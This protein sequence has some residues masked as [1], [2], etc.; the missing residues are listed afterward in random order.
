M[1]RLDAAHTDDQVWLERGDSGLDGGYGSGD[2]NPVHPERLGVRCVA[3]DEHCAAGGLGNGRRGP[4]AGLERL[5]RPVTTRHQQSRNLGCGKQGFERRGEAA[6]FGIGRSDEKEL[7]G[8][9]VL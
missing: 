5:E 1:A 6:G 8:H 3:L 2:V 7:C 9:G 4:D